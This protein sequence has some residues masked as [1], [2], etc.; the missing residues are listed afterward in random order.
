[1]LKIPKQEY[2]AEFKELAMQRVKS[3][4]TVGAVAGDLRLAEPTLRNRV[5][6][7]NTGKLHA[8]RY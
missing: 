8:S 2:M 3:G 7:A 1:M 5:N 6:A 4:E